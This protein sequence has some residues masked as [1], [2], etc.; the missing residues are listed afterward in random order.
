MQFLTEWIS[1]IILLIF[2]ATIL[3]LLLPNS[4]LQRYVKMVVGLLL[5]SIIINPLFSIFSKDF[6]SLISN[7]DLTYAQTENINFSIE[8]KKKEIQSVQLAYISEQVAVQLKRQVEEEM[9]TKFDKEVVEVM[10][11]LNDFLEE[12]D[13]LNS[14]VQVSIL[15]KK[16]DSDVEEGDKTIPVVALVDIDTSK[17]VEPLQETT[18]KQEILQYLATTWTIPI[19]KVEVLMEGGSLDQ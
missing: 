4:S 19:E 16:V 8:S 12:D 6:N 9:I 15:L 14:I 1:N 13:Y 10:V 7:I 2:L 18:N 11:D 17:G 5:L 3:E